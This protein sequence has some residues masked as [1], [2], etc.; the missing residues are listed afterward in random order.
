MR[1]WRGRDEE[2]TQVE[3]TKTEA[4]QAGRG[5][6]ITV[7]ILGMGGVIVAFLIILFAYAV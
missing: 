2:D 1:I 6:N 7:L 5:Y 4:R 3:L